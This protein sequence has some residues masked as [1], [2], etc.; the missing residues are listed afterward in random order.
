MVSTCSVW[1]SEGELQNECKSEQYTEIERETQA[2]AASPVEWVIYLTL[3]ESHNNAHRS[4]TR[5]VVKQ[6][7][8][9]KVKYIAMPKSKYPVC[10]MKD[11]LS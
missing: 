5:Y 7:K 2:K 3:K 6:G 1:A 8:R 10:K 9:T 4:Y 11:Y